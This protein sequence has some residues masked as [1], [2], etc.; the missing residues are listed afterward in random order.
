MFQHVQH[1]HQAMK[2]AQNG[3]PAVVEAVGRLVGLAGPER[4]ALAR[5]K[6]PGWAWLVAGLGVGALVVTRY[7]NVVPAKVRGA[8]RG[9]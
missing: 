4:D 7:P 9:K 5:G 2:A 6:I 1:A 8:L 3:S